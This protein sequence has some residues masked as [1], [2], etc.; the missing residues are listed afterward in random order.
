NTTN[1][2]YDIEQLW[3]DYA[4]LTPCYLDLLEAF[5]KSVMADTSVERQIRALADDNQKMI[6]ISRT[7]AEKL[8]QLQQSEV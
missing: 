8:R 4:K 5:Q 7:L 3:W 6:G 1:L 2:H